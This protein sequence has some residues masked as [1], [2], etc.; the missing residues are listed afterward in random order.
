MSDKVLGGMV[1]GSCTV[2]HEHRCKPPAAVTA[3]SC[4]WLPFLPP[5]LTLV[6]PIP[7]HPPGVPP[8]LAAMSL[9][10]NVNL[11]GSLSHYASGQAAA[12]ASSGYMRLDEMFYVGAVNGFAA[13]ALWGVVG[14]PV[15][16]L[17]GWW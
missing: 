5:H 3:P 13:L 10:Y 1:M 14:M 4:P 6:P 12:Y 8:I 9:S 2:E 7:A 15:W 17:L 16:K 11:F